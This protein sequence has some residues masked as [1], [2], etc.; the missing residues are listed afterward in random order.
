MDKVLAD[1]D[2]VCGAV[3]DTFLGIEG[4]F[5]IRQNE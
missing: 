2:M 5:F 4:L 3:A 1:A